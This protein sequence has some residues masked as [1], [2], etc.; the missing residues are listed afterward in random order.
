MD[1]KAEL[2]QE[3]GDYQKAYNEYIK[4]A[5]TYRSRGYDVEADMMEKYAKECEKEF[6]I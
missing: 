6:K 4:M 3:S 2:Y 1:C 5:E